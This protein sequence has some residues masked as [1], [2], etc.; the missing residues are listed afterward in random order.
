MYYYNIFNLY[1]QYICY[2]FKK[3]KGNSQNVLLF[4]EPYIKRSF[5]IISIAQDMKFIKY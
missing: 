1:L 5:H 4:Y 3:R 2:A